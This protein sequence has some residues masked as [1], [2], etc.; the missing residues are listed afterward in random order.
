MHTKQDV[1]DLVCEYTNYGS[2]I[3]LWFTNQSIDLGH[4][5]PQFMDELSLIE[6]EERKS[7]TEELYALGLPHK[8]DSYG[9]SL[10]S[11]ISH[12]LHVEKERATI[13]VPAPIGFG[14]P[15]SNAVPAVFAKPNEE[16][17]WQLD[18]NG[19]AIG[20]QIQELGASTR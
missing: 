9:S 20:Y 7:F 6:D 15:P 2:V 4:T 10:A 19:W 8:P 3:A 17:R 13:T 14:I 18:Q 16:V 5:I 11:F 1:V 12:A